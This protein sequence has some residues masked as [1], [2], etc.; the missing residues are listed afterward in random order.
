MIDRL[1]RTRSIFERFRENP[2][3]ESPLKHGSNVE[4]EVT[5]H[6]IANDLESASD[7]ADDQTVVRRHIIAPL[8]F[9]FRKFTPSACTRRGRVAEVIV[10]RE[11]IRKRSKPPGSPL[12]ATDARS[13]NI[14]SCTATRREA[15]GSELPQQ[16]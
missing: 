5:D 16:N 8:R 15:S 1:F 7:D 13:L 9:D 6:Q 2:D 3:R 14:C 10:R 4:S 11:G 12:V